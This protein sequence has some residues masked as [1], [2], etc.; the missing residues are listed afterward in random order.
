MSIY[1][2]DCAYSTD[3]T[4]TFEQNENKVIKRFIQDI[5]LVCAV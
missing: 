1:L 4:T 5:D 3:S 2:R